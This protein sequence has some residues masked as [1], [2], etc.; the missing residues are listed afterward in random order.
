MATCPSIID[1][2]RMRVTALDEVGN[3]QSG[4]DNSYVTDKTITMQITP[5]IEAGEERTLKGCGGC[6]IATSKQQ[7]RLKRWNLEV[8]LGALE[9]GL[10]ALMTG[11]EVI[12]DGGEA[13]GMKGVSQLACDFEPQLVAVEAWANTI[14]ED[15]PDPDYPFAYF[16]W[17]AAKFNFGQNSIG[18][19]FWQPTLAGQS[20]SNS[21]WGTG[22]YDD[23]GVTFSVEHWAIV[24]VTAM[25]DAVCGF[26]T[27]APG[28]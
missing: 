20:Q 15:A 24:Q 4:A 12:S 6:I 9:P 3:V 10:F 27:V 17:P 7:D 11:T 16:V 1:F 23:L 18:Q 2:C 26:D 14:V 22:P 21:L 28:S 13:I 8:S 25:P 5:D 19:D